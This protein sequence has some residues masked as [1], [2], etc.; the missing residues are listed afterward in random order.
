M[1]LSNLF[2]FVF[3]ALLLPRKLRVG[4]PDVLC[5][6][7]LLPAPVRGGLSSL[8]LSQSVKGHCTSRSQLTATLPLAVK[9]G[10]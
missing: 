3:I 8:Y 1:D 9:G 4:F 6:C 10:I 7:D 2:S 5:D